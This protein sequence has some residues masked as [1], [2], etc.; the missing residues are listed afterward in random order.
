VRGVATIFVQSMLSILA[1]APGRALNVSSD[2]IV[3]SEGFQGGI[4]ITLP[5]QQFMLLACKSA[6]GVGRQ[7]LL[8]VDLGV[9]I[10][11]QPLLRSLYYF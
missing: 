8:F 5:P 3:L 2:I 11:Q 9:A 6:C 4:Q 1:N 10:Q 7:H